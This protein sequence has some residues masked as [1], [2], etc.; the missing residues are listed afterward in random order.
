M[1][2]IRERLLKEIIRYLEIC[3]D[4]FIRSEIELEEY[5]SLTNVKFSFIE[6]ILNVEGRYI[7]INN[8]LESKLKRLYY[9]DSCI[10]NVQKSASGN[11]I[12]TE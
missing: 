12:L 7:A 1:E 10:Y 11:K 8:N 3:Q 4:Y 9:T 2:Y 6:N 5:Y